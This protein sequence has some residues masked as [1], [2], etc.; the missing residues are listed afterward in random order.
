MATFDEL[1]LE[2]CLIEFAESLHAKF[3]LHKLNFLPIGVSVAT[4]SVGD[5]PARSIFFETILS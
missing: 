5:T 3:Y 4:L 2:I 1:V